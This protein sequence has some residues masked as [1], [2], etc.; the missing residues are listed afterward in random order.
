MSNKDT[1]TA[2]ITLYPLPKQR[3]LIDRA[4]AISGKSQ[5]N[6]ILEAACLEAESIL[7]DQ[8][9]FKLDKKAFSKFDA[10]L[11]APV[12]NNPALKAFLS[13]SAPWES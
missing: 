7:L 10:T 1:H 8:C 11:K 9:F 2:T 6:F 4:C 3:D 5:F 13:K 12:K